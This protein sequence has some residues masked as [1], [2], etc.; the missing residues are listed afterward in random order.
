MP[1]S[2]QEDLSGLAWHPRALVHSEGSWALPQ[3]RLCNT[4]EAVVC[5]LQKSLNT[6]KEPLLLLSMKVAR[7]ARHLLDF[8]KPVS[9]S[10]ALYYVSAISKP[11][12]KILISAAKYS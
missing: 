4:H 9:I 11:V 10:V 7:Q 5:A 6:F 12:Q 3:Y 1:A 8:L 2:V